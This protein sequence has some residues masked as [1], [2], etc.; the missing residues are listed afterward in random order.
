MKQKYR[1]WK[2]EEGKALL[3]QEYAVLTAESRKQKRPGLID[4][5]FSL[6]CE[7]TYPADEIK[8]ATSRGK[9]E[10][11][12]YMRNQHFF[13]T[14]MYMDIIADAV[15]TMYATKGE[16]RK[17]LV[18]DDREILL[19][20]P[21]EAGNI[22]I[23]EIEEDVNGDGQAENIDGLLED[24]SPITKSNASD[25]INPEQPDE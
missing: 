16:Q 7:Q 11:I 12:Q 8:Q 1:I 2:K 9:D 10:L 5:N 13:P 21:P 3:I 22:S 19:G 14:G 4:E 15:T 18:L 25:R 17:D 6:L 23:P 20:T 24:N